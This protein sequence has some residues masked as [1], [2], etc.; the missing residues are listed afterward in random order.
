MKKY[1]FAILLIIP[2]LTDAQNRNNTL[3]SWVYYELLSIDAKIAEGRF[4]EAEEDYLEMVNEYWPSRSFDHAIILKNYGFFLIQQDRPDEGLKFLEW[5]LRKRALEDRDEH[6]LYYVISQIIASN[7][8]YQKALNYLLDWYDKGKRRNY[9][10]TPKGVAL[11]AICYSQLDEFEPAVAYITE[12]VE[13]SNIFVKSWYELK[14]ALHYKLEDFS[15]ALSTSQDLVRNYPREKKYLEQITDKKCYELKKLKIEKLIKIKVKKNQVGSDRLA[16]A[17][18]VLETNKNFIIIDFGTATTFDIVI[19]KNYIGGV[20]APGVQLSLDNLTN[21]ASLIPK[22]NLK[23]IKNVI[24]KNTSS[25]IYSGFYLGYNGLIDNIIKLIIK[26]TR[27]KF[28][29]VLTGGLSHLFKNSINGKVKLDKDLTINGLLKAS[30]LI[31]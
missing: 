12:A 9:E 26:Q 11:I 24:G 3:K 17:I 2:F 6:H 22:I 20:I 30:D 23:K 15:L 13:N 29:I 4:A 8:D 19:N 28:M 10:L 7:G 18:S 16:N 14:F 25:A 1:I 31:K 21:R 5:S 27:K